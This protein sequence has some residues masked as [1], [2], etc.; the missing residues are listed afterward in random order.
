MDEERGA[1]EGRWSPSYNFLLGAVNVDNR[2]DRPHRGLSEDR[3]DVNHP[4]KDR[5]SKIVVILVVKVI[6]S[7]FSNLIDFTA[8][9]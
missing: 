9:P 1:R 8:T 4:A 3:L 6:F 7:A 2:D 5:N